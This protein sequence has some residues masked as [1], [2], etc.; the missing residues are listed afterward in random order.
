MGE[1]VAQRLNFLLELFTQTDSDMEKQVSM[2]DVGA[3]LGLEKDESTSLAEELIIDE[4]VELKT[5][6]GGV[7]ITPKGIDALAQEGYA[8]AHKT[9][10]NYNLSGQ[11]ILT[12]EDKSAIHE[13]LQD[14]K[15]S[16]SG[17][18]QLLEELII[19]IKT[20]EV[21]LLSPKAKS[22]IIKEILKSLQTQLKVLKQEGLANVL[23]D[24]TGL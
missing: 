5:L 18:Y 7:S 16:V 4:M 8:A 15:T 24:M 2:H 21:Q 10:S 3:A 19:D 14:V 1:V 17:D 11:P 22:S 9:G 23:S 6:A 12:E 13:V 20:I